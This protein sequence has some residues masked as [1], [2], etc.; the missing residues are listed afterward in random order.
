MKNGPRITSQGIG[1]LVTLVSRANSLGGHVVFIHTTPFVQAVFETTKISRFLE[2][3]ET[4]EEGVGRWGE[5][6]SQTE[7]I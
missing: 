4:A 7:P 6:V 1:L 2:A 5:S 3:C